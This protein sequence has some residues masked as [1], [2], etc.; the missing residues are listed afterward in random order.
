MFYMREG[1]TVKDDKITVMNRRIINVDGIQPNAR[2]IVKEVAT[3]Y[4]RHLRTSLVTLVVHGS[5]VKG[6]I[7]VGSSDVDLVAF[8]EPSILMSGDE[9][10]LEHALEIHRDLASI[11][12]SPFRYLSGHVYPVGGGPKP[13]FIPGTYHVIWGSGDVSIATS[14]ELLAAARASLGAVDP[15][16]IR[17]RF[18]NALLDHGEDRLFNLMRLLC[19]KVWPVMYH[20]AC[21][22]HGNALE[23]WQR[24]KFEVFDLLEDDPVIGPALRRW[25]DSVAEHYHSG[26]SLETALEGIHA[27]VAFIDVAVEWFHQRAQP[28][29]GRIVMTTGAAPNRPIWSIEPCSSG[30]MERLFQVHRQAMGPYIQ[31]VWG[32]DEADQRHRF[33]EFDKPNLRKIVVEETIVG[34]LDVDRMDD[35]IYIGT[36][37]LIPSLQG[38]G[39]GSKILQDLLTEAEAASMPIRLQVLKVNDRA[40]RLYESLGFLPCGNTDTHIE[41]IRTPS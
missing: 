8:V 19:T 12:P 3:V 28:A 21:I 9:L 17:A 7:I 26:E 15:A 30:D 23:V 16:M 5:A 34:M 14:S 29:P 6:G 20:V 31:R 33:Q 24:T 2:D 32:W 41:M 11:D 18:S 38:Y 13:G 22:K 25:M 35:E 10:P 36:I 40:R 39:I 27:G 37:E 1:S 4:L